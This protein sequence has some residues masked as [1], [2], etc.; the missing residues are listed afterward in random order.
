M[1]NS[2]ILKEVGDNL[3]TLRQLHRMSEDEL[4]HK[5]GYT[6]G[7]SA[8]NRIETGRNSVP[9]DKIPAFAETFGMTPGDLVNV[10]LGVKSKD[11][12]LAFNAEEAKELKECTEHILQL[13]RKAG[14]IG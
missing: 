3:R 14:Y 10:L 2:E 5:V 8:I 9:L 6:S 7:R 1:N 11:V 13:F 4:G 12:A